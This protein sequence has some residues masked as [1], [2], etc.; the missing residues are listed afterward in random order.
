MEELGVPYDLVYAKRENMKAPANF[1]SKHGMGKAPMLVLEDG[2]TVLMES[3]AICD[4]I[5]STAA[6]TEKKEQFFG[7]GSEVQAA[8]VRS[9]MAWAEATLALHALV[10]GLPI[11]R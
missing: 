9:W 4:Y 10:S 1:K 7:G 5:V 2:E 6:S 3:S 11:C 8:Q